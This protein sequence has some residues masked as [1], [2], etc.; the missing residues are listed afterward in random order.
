MNI[1]W[2]RTATLERVEDAYHQ[3]RVTE[4]EWEGYAHAWRTGAYRFGSTLSGYNAHE[5]PNAAT[6]A[7]AVA[8]GCCKVGA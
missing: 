2:M 4:D 5:F 1:E 6:E 8:L 7:V 3:G